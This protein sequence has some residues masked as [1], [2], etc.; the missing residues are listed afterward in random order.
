MEQVEQLELQLEEEMEVETEKKEGAEEEK[1]KDK[2]AALLNWPP[3]NPHQP[4]LLQRK[5]IFLMEKTG[6]QQK[7]STPARGYLER[8]GQTHLKRLQAARK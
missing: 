8:L 6:A 2:E 4:I 5:L 7:H 3:A 1:D